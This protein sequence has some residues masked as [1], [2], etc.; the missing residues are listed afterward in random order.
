M[1]GVGPRVAG[2][3]AFLTGCLE[4]G[5]GDVT[6]LQSSWQWG[7][8][9]GADPAPREPR[10]CGTQPFP[11]GAGNN[12]LPHLRLWP[13]LAH[14]ED[15]VQECDNCRVCSPLGPKFTNQT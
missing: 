5:L 7:G 15:S 12:R 4:A 2:Q 8:W 1:A 14:S 3:K 10:L 9:V 11:Q 6:A 13:P